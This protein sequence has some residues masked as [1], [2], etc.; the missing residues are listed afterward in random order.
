MIGSAAFNRHRFFGLR[1]ARLRF[2]RLRFNS[3]SL[4]RLGACGLPLSKHKPRK[5]S[6][7][8]QQCLLPEGT[9]TPLRSEDRLLV[10]GVIGHR[11]I[12][13]V[14]HGDQPGYLFD[15]GF[16][17]PVLQGQINRAAALAATAELEDGY[18]TRIF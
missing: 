16:L 9:V 17:D 13:D 10:E 12:G 8:L 11:M 4:N 1:L 18:V 14:F 2:F 3:R 5:A 15:Q 7:L 6:A